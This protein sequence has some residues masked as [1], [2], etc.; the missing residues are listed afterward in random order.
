VAGES[1]IRQ[2]AISSDR[3]SPTGRS[4]KTATAFPSSQ[5]SFLDRH[6]LNVMLCQVSLHEVGER[7]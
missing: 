4:P 6:R 5:R 7:Q 1:A 3:S 2:A